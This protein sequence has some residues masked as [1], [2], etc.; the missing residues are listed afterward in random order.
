MKIDTKRAK[1]RFIK[2]VI[3]AVLVMMLL[4]PLGGASWLCHASLTTAEEEDL[5]REFMRYV[6]K[7]LTLIED[8]SIVNYVNKVGQR[9]LGSV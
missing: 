8:P 9:I 7:N 3:V 4:P 5:G 2:T 1:M 6:R